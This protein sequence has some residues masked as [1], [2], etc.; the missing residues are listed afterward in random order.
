MGMTRAMVGEVHSALKGVHWVVNWRT[1]WAQDE[2]SC[3]FYVGT[4]PLS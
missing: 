1:T 3:K 4:C 2:L